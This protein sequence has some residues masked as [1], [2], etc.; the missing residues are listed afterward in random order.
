[1]K[2]KQ[3]MIG[4]ALVLLAAS[5]LYYTL[6]LSSGTLVLT[7]LVTT[8]EVIVSPQVTGRIDRL[9]V[10]EG[11]SVKRDQLLAL[12]EP[13]ELRADSAYYAYSAEGLASQVKE[14]EVALR[15]QE[16]QT[17]EQIHQA[18]AALAS[19]EAQQAAAQAD[20]ENARLLFERNRQLRPQGIVSV[21]EF[22]RTRTAYDGAKAR[23]DSLKRQAEAAGAM[24]EL[25]R[26]NAEQIAMKKHALGAS[27]QQ[28]AAADAQKAKANVRLAYAEIH[29]PIDANVDVLAVR[30]GGVVSPGQPL[31]TLI[32]P[33]DLWVRVDVE[34]TYIDRIRVGDSMTVRLPSGDERQGVVFFRGIDA[35]FATQRD[36][37][38]F[39]RDI[40]TFEVRLRVDNHDRR[41]AVGMTAYVQLALSH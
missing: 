35:G 13:D 28:Q 11:D 38:R 27:Q 41:L 33:D 10:H 9:L 3:L 32:D 21:E 5:L 31:L 15:L 24:L 1:M 39:K 19:A 16:Q 23:V 4:L 14:S 29:A 12:I 22:D 30:M 18:E 36:V 25:A 17:T 6:E 8:H 34:E 26:S 40:K 37:S 2:R 20:S 7:G